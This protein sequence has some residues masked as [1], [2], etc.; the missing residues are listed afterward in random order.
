MVINLD[1]DGSLVTH[2]YP[3]IGKDIG[4]V[5]VLRRLIV[6]GHQ[7]ILFTMRSDSPEFDGLTQAVNWFKENGLPL[8]GVQTN[9]SQSKWTSSPKSYAP[10]MIDD[11]ALGCPMKRDPQLSDRPFVDWDLAEKLLEERGV[12]TE[13]SKKND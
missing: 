1:F 3:A 2:D 7:F 4:S 8:F 13:K 5:R 9:P 11:S 10:L 6:E 12:L